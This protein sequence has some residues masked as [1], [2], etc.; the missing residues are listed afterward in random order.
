LILLNLLDLSPSITG[1]T[2]LNINTSNNIEDNICILSNKNS[3][4]V[5][6]NSDSTPCNNTNT[7]DEIRK[8]VNLQ[9]A[10]IVDENN[11]LLCNYNDVVSGK[12][13]ICKMDQN[14]LYSFE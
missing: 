9:D 12:F 6:L 8:L 14:S 13:L 2:V 1:N 3:R 7:D 10:L 4:D 11:D 5:E